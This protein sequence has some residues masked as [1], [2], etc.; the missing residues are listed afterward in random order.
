MTET[1]KTILI[2]D[3]DT[4]VLESL[5]GLLRAYGY[6]VLTCSDPRDALGKIKNLRI[7]VVLTDIKMP[8]LSGTELLGQIHAHNPQLPVILMTAFADIDSAISAVKNGAFDFI[9][10]P[11]KPDYLVHAVEKAVEYT[12]L[13]EMEKEYKNTLEEMV[14]KRTEEL[15][16]A[17]ELVKSTSREL[18]T[19]LTVVAEYRDMD[20]GAHISR[21][22]MYAAKIAELLRMPQEFVEM[23]GFASPMH[24]IG[25]IGIPD[26]ILLKPCFLTKEEFDVMKNH[27]LIGEKMLR[28]STSRYIQ[29]A[30][31]IALN[32]HERWDGTGYPRG[33][34]AEQIPIEGRIVMIADQYDALRSK[35]PYKRSFTHEEACDIIIRGDDRTKPG[36][37]DPMILKV[38]RENADVFA[39][40]YDMHRD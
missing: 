8:E 5:A 37:F 35:R 11:Y 20:T 3:D 38:F 10:K 1:D 28:D 27:T 6:F 25:K 40:I 18:V 19:R 21:M 32:H 17:L 16:A 34:K 36:H 29:L 22:G 33:L 9:T 30:A 23:I 4:Y 13:L 31:S 15:S 14:R 12:R 7:D 39:E 2:V 24:D 26:S